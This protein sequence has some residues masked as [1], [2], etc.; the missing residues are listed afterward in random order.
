MLLLCLCAQKTTV[1]KELKTGCVAVVYLSVVKGA[2]LLVSANSTQKWCPHVRVLNCD[3]VLL[4]NQNW[5]F[6]VFSISIRLGLS[7]CPRNYH[8]RYFV[9]R[10]LLVMFLS[11]IYSYLS[12]VLIVIAVLFHC[13][14][15]L[16]Y[17]FLV[18][19]ALMLFCRSPIRNS[20][21]LEVE[22]VCVL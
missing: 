9:K 15:S 18:C 7:Y 5:L 14:L 2:I 4:C 21:R 12:L 3:G 10:L 8:C 11:I 6:E 20:Q 1:N 13:F 22:G 19:I 16:L 17:S